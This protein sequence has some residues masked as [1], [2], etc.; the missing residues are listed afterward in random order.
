MGPGWTCSR[1]VTSLLCLP[2]RGGLG[3]GLGGGR[4]VL[5]PEPVVLSGRHLQEQVGLW[6]TRLAKRR[7]RVRR[8]LFMLAMLGKVAELKTH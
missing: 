6:L 5:G 7:G 1:W 3:P 2:A 4:A 8:I